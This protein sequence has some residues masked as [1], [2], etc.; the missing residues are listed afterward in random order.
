[1]RIW[2]NPKMSVRNVTISEVVA[3][4]REQST[5]AAT[6]SLGQQ[7]IDSQATQVTLSTLRLSERAIREHHLRAYPMDAPFAS[8]TLVASRWLPR[9]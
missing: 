3:A 5:P 4:L 9:T 8:K 7:P 6:G 1:M 2:L